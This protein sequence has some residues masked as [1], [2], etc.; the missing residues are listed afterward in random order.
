L[1][2]LRLY[3]T[4]NNETKRILNYYYRLNS[5]LLKLISVIF[6]G[7]II[8][9]NGIALLILAA[10]VYSRSNNIDI[11]AEST[12]YSMPV[13]SDCISCSVPAKSDRSPVVK[14]LIIRSTSL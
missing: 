11:Q 2:K 3:S 4:S 14:K 1:K 10:K 12:E 7:A 8:Q 5:K 9:D 13:E 6:N